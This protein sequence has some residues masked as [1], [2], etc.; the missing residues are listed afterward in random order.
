MRNLTFLAEKATS[1]P[2]WKVGQARLSEI[3]P[4]GK[5][6]QGFVMLAVASKCEPFWAQIELF[7]AVSVCLIKFL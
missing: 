6:Q 1:H 4:K 3:K 7:Q 5:G 2:Q